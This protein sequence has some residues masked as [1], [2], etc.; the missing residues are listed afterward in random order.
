VALTEADRLAAY[1]RAL[2][3]AGGTV[4][5]E[6]LAALGAWARPCESRYHAAW[7]RRTR[8]LLA[9][10]PLRDL[11][12]AALEAKLDVE[13]WLAQQRAKRAGKERAA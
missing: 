7:A 1:R 3:P 6:E 10:S 13:A 11:A 2:E 4:S 5:D 9:E 8:A 12:S